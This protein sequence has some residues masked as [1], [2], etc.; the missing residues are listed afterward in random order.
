MATLDTCANDLAVD[1]L[2]VVW[3]EVACAAAAVRDFS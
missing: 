3:L 2:G 1:V